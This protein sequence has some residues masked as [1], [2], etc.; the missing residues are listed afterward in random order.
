[1]SDP[2]PNPRSGFLPV[3]IIWGALLL[4]TV[5]Y[6]GVGLKLQ[7][8][9]SGSVPDPKLV[10][11][12]A[13]LAV[14]LVSATA[15]VRQFLIDGPLGEGRLDLREPPQFQRYLATQVVIFALCESVAVFGLVLRVQGLPAERFLAFV[16]GGFLA[17]L[18]HAPVQAR[19]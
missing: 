2:I 11:L 18:L 10:L 7:L 14:V 1:M 17:L 15:L 12:F 5:V 8:A 4:S 13:L 16:G 3:W 6:A 9:P 19:S